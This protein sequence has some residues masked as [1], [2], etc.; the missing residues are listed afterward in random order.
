MTAQSARKGRLS[1]KNAFDIEGIASDAVEAVTKGQTKEQITNQGK[2]IVARAV[3][4]ALK[5]AIESA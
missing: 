5:E 2:S 3:A 1:A 4:E